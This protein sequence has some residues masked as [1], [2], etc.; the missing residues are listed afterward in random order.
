M[1][2]QTPPAGAGFTD[3]SNI[4]GLDPSVAELLT[5]G[6]TRQAARQMTTEE[7]AA[8]RKAEARRT[9]EREKMASRAPRRATYD[10]PEG[11]KAEVER[12]AAELSAP[13]SQVAAVLLSVGLRAVQRG[14]LNL[15]RLCRPAK[16]PR[17]DNLLD[18]PVENGELPKNGVSR[19]D[20]SKK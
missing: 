11:M 3:F 1:A 12:L 5:Q 15:R 14:D 4:G 19:V 8:A 2:K 6:A 9:H 18:L 10:L 20:P 13:T 16:S 17:Y 7:R